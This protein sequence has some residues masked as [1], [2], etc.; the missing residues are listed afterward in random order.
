MDSTGR[1]PARGE[2]NERSLVIAT[3]TDRTRGVVSDTRS[4]DRGARHVTTGG[5]RAVG[6]L[7]RGNRNSNRAPC[8][9]LGVA[10]RALPPWASA[11]ASTIP[12]PSPLP[13]P[14]RA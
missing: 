8:P 13:A 2:G 5:E 7:A 6:H 14:T 3:A 1:Q 4:Q 12:S 10:S 9:V 11:I